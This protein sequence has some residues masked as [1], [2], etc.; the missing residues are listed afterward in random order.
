SEDMRSATR[1]DM[2]WII[3]HW[4]K[5]WKRSADGQHWLAE[6]ERTKARAGKPSTN[7]QAQRTQTREHTQASPSMRL[8]HKRT[9]RT[10]E[11]TRVEEYMQWFAE[12]GR[13]QRARSR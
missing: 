2:P 8:I 7:K 4:W 3:G 11:Q 10:P 13:A 5:E 9:T 6:R 1:D 12:Q